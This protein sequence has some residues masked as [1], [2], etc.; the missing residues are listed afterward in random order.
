MLGRDERL[1]GSC[2]LAGGQ[3]DHTLV[4]ATYGCGE[5]R[6]TLQLVHPSRAPDSALRTTGFA[7]VLVEGSPPAGFLEAIA[8]HVRRGEAAFEWLLEA[9]QEKSSVHEA[10][11]LPAYGH[12]P[13]VLTSP[14]VLLRMVG[15]A[16]ILLLLSPWWAAGVAEARSARTH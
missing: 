9:G 3:I 1:P 8:E 6:I 12:H 10:P 15:G 2:R 4:R 5:G 7:V 13:P 14:Q 11:G 16:V